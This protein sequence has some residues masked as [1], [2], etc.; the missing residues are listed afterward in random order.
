MAAIPDAI[1]AN[2]LSHLPPQIVVADFQSWDGNTLTIKGNVRA[3]YNN[4]L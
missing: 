4:A 2:P 1:D 3:M